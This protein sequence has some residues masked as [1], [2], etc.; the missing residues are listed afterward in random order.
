[1]STKKKTRALCVCATVWIIFGLVFFWSEGY[2]PVDSMYS[3]IQII[4]TV[5]YG[6]I[7]PKTNYQKIITAIIVLSSTL[8]MAGLRGTKAESEGG[9][10]EA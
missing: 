8:L 1:M 7:V 3:L 4:T 10:R 5:G 2:G 6:D 9:R